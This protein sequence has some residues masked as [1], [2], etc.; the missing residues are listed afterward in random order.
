MVTTCVKI[1]YGFVVTVEEL[2]KRGIDPTL[3]FEFDEELDDSQKDGGMK[4]SRYLDPS[5]SFTELSD[6][7]L[8]EPKIIM[9]RL[10]PCCSD[11]G[12]YIIGIP[13]ASYERTIRKRVESCAGCAEYFICDAHFGQ[14]T[15]GTYDITGQSSEAT[16]L[17]RS[18]I[19]E[20]KNHS[21]GGAG[22]GCGNFRPSQIN[23]SIFAANSGVLP[24]VPSEEECK[25]YAYNDDCTFCS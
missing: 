17:D 14:T 24:Y 4:Y 18:T 2:V 23:S 22:C 13:I 8:N 6:V 10:V 25:F 7:L 15:N 9:E 5:I 1:T 19:C 21:N 3:F 12:K 16:E 20:C 11:K